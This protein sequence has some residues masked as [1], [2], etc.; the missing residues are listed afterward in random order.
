MRYRV[1]KASRAALGAALLV[2]GFSETARSAC[3]EHLFVIARSKNA[4]VVVYDAKLGPSGGLAEQPISAYWLLDG[5]PARR[6]ELST[7]EFDR[8]YGFT[9]SPAREPGTYTLEFKAR[10]G[11]HATVRMREGCPVALMKVA[12]KTAIVRRIYVKSKETILLPKVEYI[13]LFG[14]DPA[15]GKHLY[16]KIVL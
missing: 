11:R 7:I 12:G 8:A 15:T 5:D 1:L 16:E 3:R 13:E 14:E 4:N 2:L 9:T 10:R 6:E